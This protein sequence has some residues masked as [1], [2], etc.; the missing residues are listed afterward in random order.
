MGLSR[1]MGSCDWFPSELKIMS[2]RQ[3]RLR[4]PAEIFF[5]EILDRT[6]PGVQHLSDSMGGTYAAARDAKG[7]LVWRCVEFP[8]GNGISGL[9]QWKHSHFSA[10]AVNLLLQVLLALSEPLSDIS[11]FR[12]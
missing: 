2:T 8:P 10:E 4:R 3:L 11:N 9:F 5:L 1:I 12:L 6:Q 7:G